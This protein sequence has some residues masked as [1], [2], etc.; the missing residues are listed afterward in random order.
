M[1]AHRRVMG[2]QS[3]C[4]QCAACHGG[5]VSAE[6]HREQLRLCRVEVAE[7][8]QHTAIGGLGRG[9]MERGKRL[10]LQGVLAAA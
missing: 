1:G 4:R 8:E 10:A 7:R 3:T 5:K 6:V 9:G 2:I